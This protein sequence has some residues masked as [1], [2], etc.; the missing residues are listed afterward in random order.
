MLYKKQLTL[1]LSILLIGLWSLT[2]SA[3]TVGNPRSVSYTKTNGQIDRHTTWDCVYFGKYPQADNGTYQPIKWRVLSVNGNDAFLLSDSILDCQQYN[4]GSALVTWET[5]SLRTWLNNDFYKKAFSASE[6]EAILSTT[7]TDTTNNITK[8]SGGN[9]TVDKV[10]LLSTKEVLREIYGFSSDYKIISET[11]QSPNTTYASASGCFTTDDPTYTPNG[12]WWLRSP[13]ALSDTAAYVNH[14]GEVTPQGYK[15]SRRDVGV[16]P[17]LHLNLSFSSWSYAGTVSSD[18][19]ENS[20]SQGDSKTVSPSEEG[21]ASGSA[22]EGTN[23]NTST[24]SVSTGNTSTNAHNAT[25]ATIKASKSTVKKGKKSTVK[26]TANSGGKI[27]VK[28]KS[29]NA[30][31]K[32]YV[33]IKN[34]KL[35]FSKK[36]AKGKYTFTVTSAAKGNYKKTTKT[37]TIRVK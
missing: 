31:N 22:K 14:R 7:V 30:K 35:T 24:N 12:W 25:S 9:D 32:E 18:P 21:N 3:S 5:S 29:K 1:I 37:I 2:I 17:C 27:T 26:I 11:R 36:A 15:N 6:K 13:G 28:A 4:S 23:N 10:Y 16:R 8:I 34:N 20:S 33:K 19:T